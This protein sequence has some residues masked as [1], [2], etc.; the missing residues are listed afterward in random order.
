M[1]ERPWLKLYPKG[2]PANI[3]PDI[4]PRLTDMLD[5]CFKKY[6]NLPAFIFMDK[7]LTFKEVDELSYYFAAYLQSRGLEPGDRIALMMPNIMQYPIAL[8]GA[9]RAGLIVV[10]TNPLYTPREMR[11]QFIDSGAK[12]YPYCRKLCPQ[13]G[14]NHRRD[15][16]SDGHSDEYRRDARPEGPYC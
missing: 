9:L 2:V 5:A 3:N 6:S 1:T 4:Y 8:F 14:T 16:H 15:I 10:N 12:A 13:F 11:H 7:V